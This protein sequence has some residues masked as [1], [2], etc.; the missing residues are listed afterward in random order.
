MGI[1][2][3][4]GILQWQ[5]WLGIGR[6]LGLLYGHSATHAE[7]DRVVGTMANPN[8]FALLM[9]TG[10]GIAMGASK[11]ASLKRQMLLIGVGALL[12]WATIITGSRTGAAGVVIVLAAGVSLRMWGNRSVRQRRVWL[13]AVLLMAVFVG[14]VVG[15]WVAREI[16][17]LNAMTPSEILNY[18]RQGPFSTL[19]Y[20]F[21]VATSD[22]HGIGG[23][24]EI[25]RSHWKLFRQSPIL[26]WGP[27][28]SRY[29]TTID[30]E[31]VLYL[32]RYGLIGMM[33]LLILYWHVFRFSWRLLRCRT[34][35]VWRMGASIMAILAT[36]L[37]ANSVTSTFYDLQL[38]S[39]FWLIVGLGYSMLRFHTVA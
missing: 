20:R 13:G 4:I 5:N 21:S 17:R 11:D 29:E 6:P 25:W 39:F 1:A 35:L 24:I 8:Q 14:F 23:R 22:R 19:L 3:L 32:R 2:A 30:S 26:G 34:D 31:Y 37:V 36:Y 18:V 28:K 9:A 10:L 7:E 16:Q 12:A 38:M 15:P 33:C 27:G